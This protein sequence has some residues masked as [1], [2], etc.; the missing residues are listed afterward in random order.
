MGH[1]RLYLIRQTAG[2]NLLFETLLDIYHDYDEPTDTKMVMML[3]LL[4][5]ILMMVKGTKQ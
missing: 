5:L 4:M 2:I 1:Q 3:I